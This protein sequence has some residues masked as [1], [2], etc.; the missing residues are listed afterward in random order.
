MSIVRVLAEQMTVPEDVE[1]GRRPYRMFVRDLVLPARI[2]VYAHEHLAPQKIRVNAVAPT[3]IET[4]LTRRLGA[5][6]LLV[7]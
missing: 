4:P 5:L 1:A 3:Y 2:G 6:P 7:S